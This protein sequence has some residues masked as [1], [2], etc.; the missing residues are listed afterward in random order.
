MTTKQKGILASLKFETRANE[1]GYVVSKPTTDECRY[2]YILDDNNQRLR[3]QIKYADGRTFHSKG[4]VYVSLRKD[5]KTRKK[6]LSY[7][8]QDIDA[9]V[10]YVPKI[11][12]LCWFGPKVFRGK[13]A[14]T[15]RYRPPENGQKKLLLMAQDYIW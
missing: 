8:Q 10:V 1:Q 13:Q 12:A 7:S 15:I 9:L 14:L 5:Q 11:D 2:D 4:A 6:M 3:V